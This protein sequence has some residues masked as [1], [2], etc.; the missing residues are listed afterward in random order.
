MIIFAFEIGTSSKI[1]PSFSD[2]GICNQNLAFP[3]KMC[4]SFQMMI[5]LA[6]HCHVSVEWNCGTVSLLPRIHSLCQLTGDTLP[7]LMSVCQ[8]ISHQLQVFTGN[9]NYYF[10]L[11][12]IFNSFSHMLESIAI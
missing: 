10:F 4:L 7:R 9:C 2:D 12:F 5:L 1:V 6:L 3:L 8:R 11:D